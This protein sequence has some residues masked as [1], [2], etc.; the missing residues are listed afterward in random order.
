V[1]EALAGTVLS[2]LGLHNLANFHTS[3][4]KGAAV[5]ATL[6]GPTFGATDFQLAY[7]VGALPAAGNTTIGIVAEGDLSAVLTDLVQYETLNSLPKV[8][9]NVMLPAGAAPP[10]DTSGQDEFDLDSQTSTGLA[11]NVA[12]LDMYDA[13]S[14]DD[15]DLAAAFNLFVN[16]SAVKVASVSIG[17][18]EVL[19]EVEGDIA[20][21]DQLFEAGV[22]EGKTLF[23]ATGDNGAACPVLLSENGIPDLGLVGGVE[24]PASSPYVVAVGG[25]TLTVNANGS[26]ASETAWDAGGG[27]ISL[28][29]KA[30]S[31][32][33]S[34]V[35]LTTAVGRGIPDIAMDADP[36]TGAVI[37]V[38]GAA[39]TVGG[40]S[41]AA[42]LSNG[43][44]ARIQDAHGGSLG[45]AAPLFYS[46]ATG[47][48]LLGLLASIKGFHD[49]TSGFNGLY[50]AT[51]GWDYCTGLGTFDISAV[52]GLIQ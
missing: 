50:L 52:N 48:S 44:F 6:G 10:T 33:K 16:D 28:F 1:P 18:C 42:P 25:T 5:P 9:V 7:D 13:E 41:L 46:L 47:D 14:L 21:D 20:T 11:G 51:K 12:A 8:T 15:A 40:T 37:I 35:G 17:G 30:P 31:W 24:Y 22:A 43:A 49:I 27:G 45:F 36:D 23:V 38:N 26:Y 34:V 19:N 2:V 29:E 39:E 4:V 3:L 32:Q